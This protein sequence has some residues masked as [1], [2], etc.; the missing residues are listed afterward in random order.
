[1]RAFSHSAAAA[2]LAVSMACSPALDWREVRVDAL[3][4][5]ALFPCR[6]ERR[7][8]TV[9][10]AGE[11]VRMEL[12]SCVAGGNTYAVAF[13]DVADARKV[14]AGLGTLRQAAVDNLDGSGKSVAPFALAGTTANE[15][16][17]RLLVSGRLA[18][19]TAVQ[20]HAVFFVKGLRIYQASVVGGTA[21][22]D[23]VQTF[24]DGLKLAP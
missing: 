4:L 13:A 14:T 7:A 9:P 24:L 17:G 8:R 19:G 10:L 5:T 1:M 18:D 20:E 12:V 11:S 3:A 23:A 15:Q 2:L 6:P 22:L 16:S 21:A